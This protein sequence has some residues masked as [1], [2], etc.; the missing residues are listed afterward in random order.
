VTSISDFYDPHL[1][2]LGVGDADETE[3]IEYYISKLQPASKK[4]LDIGAGTGRFAIPLAALGHFV[5]ALDR[6]ARMLKALER[7]RD[8]VGVTSNLRVE[9]RCF[10]PR[11]DDDLV[12]AAIAP[13]DFLLHLLSPEA[14][15]EFFSDLGSW[16][17][18][19]GQLITDIRSRNSATLNAAAQSPSVCRAYP[20]V[21][22]DAG[23]AGASYVHVVSWEIYDKST[24]SLETTCQ[25]Q[26]LSDRGEVTRSFF[27]V[28]QQRIHSSR[29]IYEAATLAGFELLEHTQRN[30]STAAL[31]SDI[32]GSF[33]FRRL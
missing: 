33:S 4:V 5:L 15:I 30:L 25:Y 23:E 3:T 6:S 20:L 32:G 18:V 27:R 13:D 28:L 11:R 19:G 29:E 8:K 2:E 17:G 14:L 12:D 21:R 26:L 1:Y 7:R 31:E 16:L 10:G 22:D 9:C 24:Q